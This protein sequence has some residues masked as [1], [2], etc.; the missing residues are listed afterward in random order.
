MLL[1]TVIIMQL[2]SMAVPKYASKNHNRNNVTEINGCTKV[3]F[4]KS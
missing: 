1:K 2:K 4:Q 3:C